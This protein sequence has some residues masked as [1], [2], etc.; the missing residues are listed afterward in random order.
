MR[1]IFKE[2]K[3]KSDDIVED[4]T[5]VM[6]LAHT[7]H[8]CEG[9]RSL[10]Y[11]IGKKTEDITAQQGFSQP[12]LIEGRFYVKRDFQSLASE[13]IALECLK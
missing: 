11:G 12:M 2:R 6:D 13:T 3:I 5:C 10:I 1:A 9:H 7:L 8:Y 4:F